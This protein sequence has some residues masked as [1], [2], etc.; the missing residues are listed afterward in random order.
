[1]QSLFLQQ[2]QQK[3]KYSLRQGGNFKLPFIL[4]PVDFHWHNLSKAFTSSLQRNRQFWFVRGRKAVY[5]ARSGMAG[6]NSKNLEVASIFLLI[7][8]PIF[9]MMGVDDQEGKRGSS[10]FLSMQILFNANIPRPDKGHTDGQS[11]L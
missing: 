11:E 4:S 10:L 7:T 3:R 6:M 1:M 2:K 9:P 8:K 5:T